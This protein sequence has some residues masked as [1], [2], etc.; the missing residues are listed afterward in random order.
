[1]TWS[2]VSK[3]TSF[4][5]NLTSLGGYSYLVPI[6]TAQVYERGSPFVR[7]QRSLTSNNY[8]LPSSSYH[9]GLTQSTN[10]LTA[11]EIVKFLGCEMVLFWHVFSSAV[12]KRAPICIS[13]LSPSDQSGRVR[14]DLLLACMQ[15][16]L[17]TTYRADFKPTLK[18]CFC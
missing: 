15:G 4:D 16:R 5:T 9:V 17:L 14:S 13:V 3:S 18:V 6:P 12:P 7:S 10:F 11:S 8:R 1:M 2:N